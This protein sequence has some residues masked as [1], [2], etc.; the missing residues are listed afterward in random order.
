MSIV[1][2][3]WYILYTYF[4]F[5]LRLIRIGR[6][7]LKKEKQYNNDVHDMYIMI[8]TRTTPVISLTSTDSLT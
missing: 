4:G 8:I 3:G 1:W 6:E 5:L 2:S 7:N